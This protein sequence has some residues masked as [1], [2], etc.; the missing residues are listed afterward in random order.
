MEQQQ[1]WRR[2]RGFSPFPTRRD[3]LLTREEMDL[4]PPVERLQ[5]WSLLALAQGT[6][7][8]AAGALPLVHPR[9]FAKAGAPKLLTKALGACCVNV[10]A[11]LIRAALRGGRPRRDER[12]LALR[13]AATFAAFELQSVCRRRVRLVSLV[14]GAVQLGFIALW[15][16]TAIAERR[17]LGR[18]PVA[19]HA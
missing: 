19:A 4:E 8:V 18:P 1:T 15:G 12:G 14:D 10:G 7:Y 9:W 3:R 16:A 6:Y 5:P 13:M 11:H 17:A 2:R